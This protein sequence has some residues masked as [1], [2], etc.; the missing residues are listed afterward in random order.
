M[1]IHHSSGERKILLD[2]VCS[3]FFFLL[4]GSS[5]FSSTHLTDCVLLRCVWNWTGPKRA[6]TWKRLSSILF[7]FRRQFT[8]P[9][10]PHSIWRG[11]EA[12]YSCQDGS[13]HVIDTMAMRANNKDLRR[14]SPVYANWLEHRQNPKIKK[15]KKRCKILGRKWKVKSKRDYH[16][17][18]CIVTTYA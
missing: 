11:C 18:I 2:F 12:M 4:F 7:I 6:I 8:V 15:N 17:S 10:Y 13:Q 9:F 14:R 3:H 1:L 5:G 16:I